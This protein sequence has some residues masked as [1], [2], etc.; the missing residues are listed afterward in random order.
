MKLYRLPLRQGGNGESLRE[1]LMQ[2]S[3]CDCLGGGKRGFHYILRRPSSAP[4]GAAV[5]NLWHLA[6]G[7]RSD[8]RNSTWQ[9]WQHLTLHCHHLKLA[10]GISHCHCNHSDETAMVSLVHLRM[11]DHTAVLDCTIVAFKI[12][13]MRKISCRY[14]VLEQLSLED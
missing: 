11:I 2:S 10:L 7:R 3:L 5:N 13:S 4:S 8:A 1:K 9:H 12:Y 14:F 6:P